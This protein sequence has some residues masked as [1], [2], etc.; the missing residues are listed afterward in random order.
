MTR[1]E[2]FEAEEA[3]G[4]AETSKAMSLS[5]ARRS[6][7]CPTP[8]GAHVCAFCADLHASPTGPLPTA[9]ED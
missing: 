4:A 1:G 3:A 2:R 6:P 5:A 9:T 7:H 8:A